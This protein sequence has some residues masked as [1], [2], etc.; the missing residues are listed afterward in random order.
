[1]TWTNTIPSVINYYHV[2]KKDLRPISQT[3]DSQ[4]STI[5][6]LW[7][8]RDRHEFGDPY[9]PSLR[10]HLTMITLR[11]YNHGE[12]TNYELHQTGTSITATVTNP[13][14]QR[15]MTIQEIENLAT[16]VRHE[17]QDY[18]QPT[19]VFGKTI[20]KNWGR[21]PEKWGRSPF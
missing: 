15:P 12:T 5:L 21:D 10:G 11:D 16:I 7:I 19:S 6:S 2:P 9:Q 14:G 3:F 17:L 13:D 20:G 8:P 4:Q 18:N 1:M